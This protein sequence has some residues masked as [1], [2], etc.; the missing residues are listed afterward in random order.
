LYEWATEG[1]IAPGHMVSDDKTTWTPA[2]SFPALRMECVVDTGKGRTY[3]PFNL[4]AAP[5]L[6]QQ[7]LIRADAAIVNTLTG[8][9][10]PASSVSG[11]DT[12]SSAR[13]RAPSPR[14]EAASMGVLPPDA[15]RAEELWERRETEKIERLQMANAAAQREEELNARLAALEDELLKTSGLL[16]K[17]Q[18][19]LSTAKASRRAAKRR[20]PQKEEPPT[21]DPAVE[22]AATRVSELEHALKEQTEALGSAR[23][24]AGQEQ[25]TLLAKIHKLEED[26]ET[27]TS[28][29]D[30]ARREI[31]L[32][33]GAKEERN[34]SQQKQERDLTAT[35]QRQGKAVD[36]LKGEVA[37]LRK[38]IEIERSIRAGDEKSGVDRER[39]LV[40]KLRDLEQ[41]TSS[42][43][44]LLSSLG[45]K[46]GESV[47]DLDS[48]RDNPKPPVAA[49]TER[50]ASLEQSVTPR[51]WFLRLEDESVFGPVSLSELTEWAADCRIGP[52]HLVST[53]REKWTVAVEV[54]E[55]G[56][57]W[58]VRLVDGNSYGPIHVAA[59]RDLLAS[60]AVSADAQVENRRTGETL[61]AEALNSPVVTAAQHLSARL[62]EQLQGLWEL[63]SAERER[64]CLLSEAAA[65]DREDAR[66]LLAGA[67]T[68][69]ADT[70]N[71]SREPAGLP[72]KSVA[73]SL[74]APSPDA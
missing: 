48:G 7:G 10:I 71:R 20:A 70:V 25:E 18:K 51:T 15:R 41:R 16:S 35:A 74:T 22:Q 21:P 46:I 36:R 17:T 54:A 47:S 14:Q 69:I 50:I 27:S 73:Q 5:H 67:A 61:Q 6:V 1:R 4:L 19:D 44:S 11:P 29:L 13:T 60:G 53:D 52:D 24:E 42:S 28:L 63:V 64:N 33:K 9:E 38:Q 32:H 30:T 31:T 72:P 58:M 8:Q 55:L 68:A 39:K 26:V 23:G 37:R 66:D 3:G 43:A 2:E 57:D 34:E 40:L 49:L 12:T 56:M 59:V 65:K 45:E 62:T